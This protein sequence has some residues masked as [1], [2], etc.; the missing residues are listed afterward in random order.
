MITT[1]TASRTNV[2]R[3]SVMTRRPGLKTGPYPDIGLPDIGQSEDRPYLPVAPGL[4]TRRTSLEVLTP[5]N[6]FV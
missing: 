5:Q 6:L 1:A 4:Q 3:F 2:N